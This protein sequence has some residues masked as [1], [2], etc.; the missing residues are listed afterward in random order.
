MSTTNKHPRIESIVGLD[1]VV[2]EPCACGC[3]IIRVSVHSAVSSQLVRKCAWC[4]R[5][6]G[7]FTDAEIAALCAYT[8]KFG[9]D[10]RPLYFDGATGAVR[11]R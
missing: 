6:K 11:A 10:L 3:A 5:R 2:P 9:W 8:D 1:I 7:K 4:R